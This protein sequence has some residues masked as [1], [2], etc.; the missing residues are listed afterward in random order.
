MSY[1]FLAFLFN[2]ALQSPYLTDSEAQTSTG[3]SIGDVSIKTRANTIESLSFERGEFDFHMSMM[4][5]Y[6]FIVP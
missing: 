1:S 5:W 3:F 4:N 6:G 2:G